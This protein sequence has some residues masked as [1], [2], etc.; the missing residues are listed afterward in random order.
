VS[1]PT[2]VAGPA[3]PGTWRIGLR[4]VRIEL[5]QFGRDREAAFSR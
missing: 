3:L 4:R 1:Q 2:R 5:L